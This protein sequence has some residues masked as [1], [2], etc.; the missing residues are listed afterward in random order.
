[1]EAVGAAVALVVGAAAFV[2][3]SVAVVALQL[4]L[5]TGRSVVPFAAADVLVVAGGCHVAAVVEVVAG[6]CRVAAVVAVLLSSPH[7]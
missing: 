5:L 3:A 6:G 4:H 2:V 1:M 7:C